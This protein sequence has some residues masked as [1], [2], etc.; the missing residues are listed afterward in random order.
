MNRLR[1]CLA[2]S[3]AVLV[4]VNARAQQARFSTAVD[5]VTMEVSVR[6]GNKAV[7]GLGPDDF[8]VT[9]NNVPQT[10]EAVSGQSLP[11]DLSLV[12][13]ASGST[14]PFMDQIQTDA[15]EVLQMLRADDRIRLLAFTTMVAQVSPYQSPSQPLDFSRMPPL[16]LTS[17]YDA[18]AAAMMRTRSE[19]RHEMIVLFTDGYDNTSTI[20]G[21]GILEVARRSD[22]LVHVFIVHPVPGPQLKEP[23]YRNTNRLFYV[24][25]ASDDL[26][27]SRIWLDDAATTTG[28]E[29]Q[30]VYGEAHVPT[31]LKTAIDGM[32]AS[33]IV[34][35]TAQNVSRPGW[36]DI[37]VKLKRP[38][39]FSIHARKGYYGGT[40]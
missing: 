31:G 6:Q 24:P 30:D 18:L 13:D 37:K 25:F 1:V 21:P 4:V 15:T 11:I 5:I 14:E 27:V 12:V 16:G 22:A 26:Q 20:G 29:L 8:I 19:D 28:G 2:A 10:V 40:K 3:L 34:R 39:E 38:G 17:I 23:K 35:Y 7:A 36:H 32:R 33:Y 9:D